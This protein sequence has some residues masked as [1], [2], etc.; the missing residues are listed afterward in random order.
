[1][2]AIDL[3]GAMNEYLLDEKRK[4]PKAHL[5]TIC[6]FKQSQKTCR[7]ICLTVNGYVCVKKTPMKKVLD[8]RYIEK[9][10]KAISDNC[11]GLG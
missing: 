2:Q 5:H 10:M 4:I 7:Y 9:K 8:E 3:Q 6:K 1:M 11:E